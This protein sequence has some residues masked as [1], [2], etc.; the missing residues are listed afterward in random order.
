[1][2]QR[3]EA[4]DFSLFTEPTYFRS[5]AGKLRYLTI[6]CPDIQ[7]AVNFVYQRMHSPNV[8]DLSLLKRILRYHKGTLTLGLQLRKDTCLSLL[9]YCDDDWSGCFETR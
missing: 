6:T 7:F 2:P 1:M 3:I 8:S 5:L 4:T 9:A